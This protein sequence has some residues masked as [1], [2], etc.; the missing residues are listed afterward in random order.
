M[1]YTL[2]PSSASTQVEAGC[3]IERFAERMHNRAPLFIC[4][5]S[6]DDIRLER[7]Q[8]DCPVIIAIRQDATSTTLNRDLLLFSRGVDIKR[9][10]FDHPGENSV[11]SG[12]TRL[13]ACKLK[14]MAEDGTD[15]TRIRLSRQIESVPFTEPIHRDSGRVVR[16]VGEARQD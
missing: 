9:A 10:A 1:A 16:C 6:L 11:R 4:C 8:H 14:N 13:N 7:V 15:C 12:R 5:S 2:C 3:T